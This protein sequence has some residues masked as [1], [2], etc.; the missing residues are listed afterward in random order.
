MA[1][2]PV[3]LWVSAIKSA[4]LAWRPLVVVFLFG[5]LVAEFNRDLLAGVVGDV[6]TVPD[7]F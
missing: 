7:V 5:L 4:P 1:I 3:E 6:P 2:S